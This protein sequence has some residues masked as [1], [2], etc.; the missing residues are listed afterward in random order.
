MSTSSRPTVPIHANICLP[1]GTFYQVKL[2]TIP[3]VGELISLFSHNDAR[4]KHPPTH[5]LEVVGIVHDIQ[6]TDQN[7]E[8][9]LHGSHAVTIHVVR[10]TSELFETVQPAES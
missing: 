2:H 4:T 5:R 10:S 8:I 6:D 1:D 9:T 3:V 7:S